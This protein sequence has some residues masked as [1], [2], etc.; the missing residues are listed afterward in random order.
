MLPHKKAK[1]KLSLNLASEQRNI[2]GLGCCAP[3]FLSKIEL[4]GEAGRYE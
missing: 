2:R 1:A 3:Q 4:E